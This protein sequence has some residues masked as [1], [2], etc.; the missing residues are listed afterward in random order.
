MPVDSEFRHFNLRSRILDS[1]VVLLVALALARISSA[2]SNWP[3]FRGPQAA[4]TSTEAPTATTW[5]VEKS[6]NIAWKTPIPGLGHS[7]PIIWGDRLF[8]TSAVNKTKTAPLKVGVYGDPSP[9]EDNDIQQWK[10]F[11]LNKRTGGILWE[12]T[13]H[14]GAPK[15]PRHPK[16]THANCTM[17]T[18]G[19]NV[20]AFFGSE[21]LYCYDLE[22]RLRWKKDLG[23][24]RA[25]P[26]VYNDTPDPKSSSLDWGFASSPII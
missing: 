18:D 19:T 22:G 21:G 15:V 2:E 1:R 20:V 10:I 14:E 23:T 24:L 3:S 25:N 13:A 12:A 16:A 11:C 17:A 6:E 9:A 4:G 5:N 7:S 8:V 26:I